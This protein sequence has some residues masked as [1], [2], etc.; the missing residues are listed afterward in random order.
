[1]NDP[2]DQIIFCKGDL[3]IASHANPFYCMQEMDGK[4]N[5]NLEQKKLKKRE[6]DTKII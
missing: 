2:V 3:S 1:M 6:K 5:P 4:L